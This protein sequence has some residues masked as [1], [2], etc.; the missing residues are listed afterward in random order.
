MCLISPFAD[1]SKHDTPFCQPEYFSIQYWEQLSY[2]LPSFLTS[3][4]RS[5]TVLSAH[6]NGPILQLLPL[7]LLP[8]STALLLFPLNS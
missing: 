8:R 3:L 1:E 2:F 7:A 6:F 4:P 5:R